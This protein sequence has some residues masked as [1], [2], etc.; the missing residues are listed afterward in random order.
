MLKRL[1]LA[2]NQTYLKCRQ[3]RFSKVKGYM[4]GISG[5]YPI[6][7][8]YEPYRQLNWAAKFFAD[9]AFLAAQAAQ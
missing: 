5:S 9:A 7:G 4:G 1:D 6:Y 3:E 2:G 8:E